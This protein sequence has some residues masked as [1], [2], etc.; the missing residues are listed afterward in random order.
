MH[1]YLNS[2]VL[3]SA[4]QQRAV[5]GPNI[6]SLSNHIA[7]N[8]EQ[9]KSLMNS[10]ENAAA[11]SPLEQQ[12]P[13]LPQMTRIRSNTNGHGTLQ[14]RQ[15]L[16]S[17]R[18][19]PYAGL[20]QRAANLAAIIAAQNNH[21][22]QYRMDQLQRELQ[23]LKQMNILRHDSSSTTHSLMPTSLALSPAPNPMLGTNMAL[24][25]QH[26]QQQELSLQM[27][28]RRQPSNMPTSSSAL[29]ELFVNSIGTSSTKFF[30]CQSTINAVAIK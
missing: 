11:V 2:A 6:D 28:M 16:F 18:V 8:S 4:A 12:E 27:M 20:Q 9:I 26:Q 10:N 14:Y 23:T 21:Q 30:F 5:S 7:M 22:Q 3:L 1:L 19:S 17:A 25:H 13:L 29:T 15:W 24:I